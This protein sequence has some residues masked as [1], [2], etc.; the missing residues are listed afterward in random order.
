M[1]KRNISHYILWVDGLGA[2]VAGVLILFL[3]PILIELY[4]LSS[5][6]VFLIA[7]ANIFYGS[8]STFL[9][10]Y[11]ERKLAHIVALAVANLSWSLIC[12]IIIYN[13][14]M[15]IFGTIHL[16]VEAL[17]VAILAVLEFRSRYDLISD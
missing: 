11:N 9:A 8:Y 2:L 6:V 13:L 10:Q 15:S 7:F 5:I 17:W 3:N 16:V 12:I 1:L 14:N 4:N